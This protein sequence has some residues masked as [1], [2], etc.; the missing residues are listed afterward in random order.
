ME[1]GAFVCKTPVRARPS[2]RQ[3]GRARASGSFKL[4]ADPH[5]IVLTVWRK[6]ANGAWQFAQDGGSVS[7]PPAAQ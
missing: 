5:A 4:Y 7:P 1:R 3:A 2:C 6:A